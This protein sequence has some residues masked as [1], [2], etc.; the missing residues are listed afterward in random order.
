MITFLVEEVVNAAAGRRAGR[1]VVG[2]GVAGRS[3]GVAGG[4]GGV[5][6]AAERS[7]AVGPD[8]VGLAAR[9]ARSWSPD[10]LDGHVRADDG[11]QAAHWLGVRDVDAG[12]IGLDSSAA[13]LSDRVGG[14]GPG[15][16]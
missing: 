10:D 15:R 6:C 8:R 13:V 16:V 7:G 1:G 12:G 11:D 4:S 5:G 14:A 9:S 2:R 3:E